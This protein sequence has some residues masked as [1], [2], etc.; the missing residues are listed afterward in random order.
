MGAALGTYSHVV[1]DRVMHADTRPLA[2]FAG[3][4]AILG[5]V[6]VGALHLVCV[7]GGGSA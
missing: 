7:A 3:T 6:A 1:L 2:P 5:A 4:N